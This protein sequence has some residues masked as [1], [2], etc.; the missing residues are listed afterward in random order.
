MLDWSLREW[1]SLLSILC[2]AG[3]LFRGIGFWREMT[4][5]EDILTIIIIGTLVVAAV[6]TLQL[7]RQNAPASGVVPWSMGVKIALLVAI[8]YWPR[9]IGR[10]GPRKSDRFSVPK[11]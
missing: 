5:L 11:N 1:S 10:L 9:I 8:I 3:L 6:G 2:I 4:V 7:D